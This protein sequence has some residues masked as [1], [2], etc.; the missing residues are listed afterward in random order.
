MT[1][2]PAWRD[3]SDTVACARLLMAMDGGQA[4]SAAVQ[5]AARALDNGDIE[6]S[7]AWR[8]VSEVIEDLSR[9]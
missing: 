4:G 1:V 9:T 8:R 2:D 6:L 3:H 5:L 7:H